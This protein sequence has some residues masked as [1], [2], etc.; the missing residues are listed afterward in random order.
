MQRIGQRVF[1]IVFDR[2][3]GDL[4]LAQI[5]TGTVFFGHKKKASAVKNHIF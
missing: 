5:Q 3:N 4:G 1:K 2:L